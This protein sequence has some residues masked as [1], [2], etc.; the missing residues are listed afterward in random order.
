M[1]KITYHYI[2]PKNKQ[3]L[4]TDFY[5]LSLF[6]QIR[7]KEDS[8]FSEIKNL[9]LLALNDNARALSSFLKKTV[10]SILLIESIK[11]RRI[12]SANLSNFLTKLEESMQE[13]NNIPWS[14]DNYQDVIIKNLN[15]FQLKTKDVF[16]Q[17]SNIPEFQGIINKL[18]IVGKKSKLS[19]QIDHIRNVLESCLENDFIEKFP[20]SD[21]NWEIFFRTIKSKD[22]WNIIRFSSIPQRIIGYLVKYKKLDYRED[23]FNNFVI[24]RSEINK[25]K[26][27]SRDFLVEYFL[28]RKNR[29][30]QAL[31]KYKQFQDIMPS[32][33]AAISSDEAIQFM[34]YDFVYHNR[35]INL[36]G[37][38][39]PFDPFRI[40]EVN[41]RK[42]F[43]IHIRDSKYEEILNLYMD[44]SQMPKEI[45]ILVPSDFRDALNQFMID[46]DIILPVENRVKE[47]EE[48]EIEDKVGG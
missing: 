10:L 18:K 11:Y 45:F 39:S 44:F 3:K 42:E 19:Y 41:E 29:I 43:A 5:L 21:K 20:K 9:L 27:V 22:I 35:F 30:R 7:L 47:L 26:E 2:V 12:F 24:K 34:C 36:A 13:D 15:N 8:S 28:E 14:Y 31:L 6:Y 46:N 32:V 4:I 37:A 23:V 1:N 38:L 16:D 25:I 33:L 40:Y 48:F 17:L